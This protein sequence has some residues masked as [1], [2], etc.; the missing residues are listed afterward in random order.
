MTVEIIEGDCRDA[1]K[2]L[3]DCSIDSCVTD[4]P[5]A[6]TA[7]KKGG[8]GVASVN[9]DSPYGRSRIGTGNGAGGFMGK[10]WD[11]GE[12]AHDPAFWAGVLR[13]LKPGAHL[14]AFGGTRTYHRMAC[15]IEDAGFEIRDQLQWIYGSGFPKSHNIGDGRG[16]ALKPASEPICLARKPLSEKT[17][18]ANVLRWGTGALNI[19]D[20]RVDGPMDGVWGTSNETT[21]PNRM[22]NGSA[23]KAAYRTRPH[24]RGRWPANVIHDGS[25]EVMAAFPDAPGQIAAVRPDSGDG[26]KTDGILGKYAT[27]SNHDPRGDS[28]SAARFFYCAKATAADRS[29]SKHPTVKPTDLMRWL[30]VLVTP[31]GG[32]VLDP[33]CGTGSTLVA[34]DRAGFNAIGIEREAQYVADAHRK[35]EKDAGM[36]ARTA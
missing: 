18:A 1:V 8:T 25:E 7:N 6:L 26:Q 27:N 4:P 5:Y 12:V 13:V 34:A 22:F 16:T 3:A 24:A 20:C 9:L 31:P 33:F 10:K 17:V 21:N 29:G 11:T 23:D 36:F 30:C 28:G 15:A 19:D 2:E 14:V 32:T 35:F